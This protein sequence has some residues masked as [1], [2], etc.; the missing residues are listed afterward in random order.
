MTQ[1]KSGVEY[2]FSAP[3]GVSKDR[4]CRRVSEPCGAGFFEAQE[5]KWD[6][7]RKCS[8]L[9]LCVKGLEYESKAATSATDR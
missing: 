6:S 7:D 5:P 3:V 1:C 2:E 8:E 4:E 9:T